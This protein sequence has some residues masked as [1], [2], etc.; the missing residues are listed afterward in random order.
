MEAASSKECDSLYIDPQTSTVAPVCAP[1]ARCSLKPVHGTP[2]RGLSC[3]CVS[4][5]FAN[6]ALDPLM[7][8]YETDS[9]CIQPRSLTDVFSVAGDV[10]VFLAKPNSTVRALNLTLQMRGSDPDRPA[11]W[12]IDKAAE[13]ASWLQLPVASG[14]GR[15][16]HATHRACAQRHR[17]ARTDSAVHR[18]ADHHRGSERQR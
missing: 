17:T 7:A 13:L 10:T 5:D 12:S 4:P 2:L 9:G 14:P 15:W 3:E 11:R 18:D 16:G 1:H 6:P 8:P